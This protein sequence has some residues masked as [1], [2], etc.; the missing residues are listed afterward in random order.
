MEWALLVSVLGG[1]ISSIF[2]HSAQDSTNESNRQIA[3]ETNEANAEQARLNREHNQQMYEQQVTDNIAMWNMQ[4]EYNSPENQVARARQAGINPSFVVGSP[5]TAGAV[6]SG[7][8][9]S[10]QPAQMQG[11]QYQSP[12]FGALNGLETFLPILSGLFNDLSQ[13]ANTD[14][15]TDQ[16]LNTLPFLTE[17]MRLDNSYKRFVNQ[18]TPS[19]M[20]EELDA[21]KWQNTFNR[22]TESLQI[23]GMQKAND[24]VDAQFRLTQLSSDHQEVINKYVERQQHTQFMVDCQN[25]ALLYQAE[26]INEKQLDE[27]ISRIAANYA[28]ANKA[29][30]EAGEARSRTVLNNQE[31]QFNED[32]KDI[33]VDTLKADRDIK[34]SSADTASYEANILRNTMHGIINEINTSNALKSATNIIDKQIVNKR[35][36]SRDLKYMLEPYKGWLGTG[37]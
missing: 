35:K 16:I 18:I 34:K 22:K 14:A 33:R 23:E 30:A 11:Y 20:F 7:T 8:Y 29:S 5:A 26:E 24:L 37:K 13:R 19:L 27:I 21:K 2:G 10:T 9:N 6:S 31:Y 28:Q 17:S 25:L 36:F 15:Q 4:N 12:M 32:T 1:L 3:R